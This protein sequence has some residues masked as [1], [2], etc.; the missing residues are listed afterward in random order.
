MAPT[1]DLDTPSGDP[2]GPAGAHP[3]PLTV[4]ATVAAGE[5]L[6]LLVLA[7][8]EIAHLTP[9]R[10][11]MNL[12][13][14]VFFL[15]CGA[16][17]VAC[18]AGLLKHATWSRSPVVLAQLFALGIAWSF[19]TGDATA[20][21]VAVALVLAAVVVLVGVLHPSSTAVLTDDPTRGDAGDPN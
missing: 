13:T 19:R 2:T 7:V 3:V 15:V 10:V 9:G 1:D 17:I 11:T 14:T 20:K 6:V 12:T 5:G 18:A 4:A 16:A 21:A 8:L